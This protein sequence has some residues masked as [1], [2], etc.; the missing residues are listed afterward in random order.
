MTGELSV[1]TLCLTPTAK[2]ADPVSRGE[3]RSTWA[4]APSSKRGAKLLWQRRCQIA[5]PRGTLP[6]GKRKPLYSIY[7]PEILAP[8]GN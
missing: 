1:P 6:P 8:R 7:K 4:L 3:N 2:A 5:S